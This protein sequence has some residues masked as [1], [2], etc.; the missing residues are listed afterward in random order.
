[1]NLKINNINKKKS[2]ISQI[3]INA[4]DDSY[5]DEEPTKQLIIQTKKK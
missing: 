4:K 2:K 3:K 5:E 1:M